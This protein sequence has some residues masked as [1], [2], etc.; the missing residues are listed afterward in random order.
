ML[1]ICRQSFKQ[2]HTRPVIDYYDIFVYRP[3]RKLSVKVWNREALW[4]LLLLLL[5]FLLLLDFAIE[6]SSLCLIA[7]KSC[8]EN[9]CILWRISFSAAEKQ[10]YKETGETYKSVHRLLKQDLHEF[11]KNNEQNDALCSFHIKTTFLHLMDKVPD[12]SEWTKDRLL[13]RYKDGLRML[14]AS[15]GKGEIKHYFIHRANLLDRQT[16]KKK[17]LKSVEQYLSRRLAT[18]TVWCLM[19]QSCSHTSTP[20]F[21]RCRLLLTRDSFL[22]GLCWLI[23]PSF[24]E[25][26]VK[27]DSLTWLPYSWI[28]LL[29]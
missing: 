10:L 8:P 7:E 29:Q 21:A 19:H 23:T 2:Q 9:K 13:D 20:M 3:T 11:K 16:S 22:L 18:Y 28:R 12:D 14:I 27:F 1:T 5:L 15:L 6:E 17:Q 24:A 26:F 25:L 4:L